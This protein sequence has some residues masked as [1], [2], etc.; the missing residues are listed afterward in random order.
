MVKRTRTT[1]TLNPLPFENLEP[2]RFEDLI[3][4]LLYGFRDWVDIEPTG[5]GGSDDG[6]DIR[7]WQKGESVSNISDEGEQGERSGLGRLWQVQGKRE[8]KR[9]CPRERL[10]A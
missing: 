10:R 1:R 8:V 2:H 6:F 9:A 5:R 4:R 7:A 3:R